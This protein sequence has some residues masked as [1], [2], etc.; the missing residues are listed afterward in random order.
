MLHRYSHHHSYDHSTDIDFTDKYGDIF[1][2]QKRINRSE[3]RGSIKHILS[4][5]KVTKTVAEKEE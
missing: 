2:V 3:I 1:V 5:I 4:N